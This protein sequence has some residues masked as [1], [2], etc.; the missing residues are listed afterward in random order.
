[1][2]PTR[3][4]T[5]SWIYLCNLTENGRFVRDGLGLFQGWSWFVPGTGLRLFQGRAPFV[6]DTILQRM[7]MFVGFLA[8]YTRGQKRHIKL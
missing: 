6:L 1:M 7:F 4:W 8:K 5:Q 3:H 2:N